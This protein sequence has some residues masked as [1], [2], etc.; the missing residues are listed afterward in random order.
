MH[1]RK[2]CINVYKLP[3]YSNRKCC[4]LHA[5]STSDCKKNLYLTIKYSSEKQSSMRVFFSARLNLGLE[6]FNFPNILQRVSFYTKMLVSCIL[7]FF[8]YDVTQR[9]STNGQL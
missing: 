4:T 3:E 8:L 9:G 6:A 5:N 7:D 1:C 2:Q